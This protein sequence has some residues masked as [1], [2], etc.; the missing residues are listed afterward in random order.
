MATCTVRALERLILPEPG[1]VVGLQA[2][3]AHPLRAV[4]EVEVGDEHPRGPA[5]LRLEWFAVDLP[6]LERRSEPC[7]SPLRASDEQLHGLPPAFVVVD[8]AD[9]LRD[10][11][12]AYAARLRAAGVPVTTV[13]YDGIHHDFMM[14]NPLSETQAT[15]AAVA[16]AASVLRDALWRIRT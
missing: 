4:P 11:G 16:Q 9:V 2:E 12:E 1:L 13:R 15:R 7:A 6:D 3:P 14:L 5:V 8:E 10:E